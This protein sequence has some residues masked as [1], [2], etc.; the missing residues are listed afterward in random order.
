MRSE[1]VSGQKLGGEPY[2]DGT[3]A[4]GRS[5]DFGRRWRRSLAREGPPKRVKRHV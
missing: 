1:D 3:L 5:M 2:H 4:T